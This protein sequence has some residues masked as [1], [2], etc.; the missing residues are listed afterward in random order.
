MASLCSSRQSSR[1][2]LARPDRGRGQGPLHDGWRQA[3]VEPA[4]RGGAGYFRF[5]RAIR[6]DV[7]QRRPPIAWT[8]E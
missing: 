1:C 4:L 7:S 2:G 8:S 5:S 6:L 3:P